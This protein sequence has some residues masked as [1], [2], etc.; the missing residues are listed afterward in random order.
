MSIMSYLFRQIAA[1]K[2]RE[3]EY[4]LSNAVEV[5][6]DK[7]LSLLQRHQDTVIGRRYGFDRITSPEKYSNSIPLS[8]YYSMEPLIKQVYEN[9]DGRILTVDPV[10][11][12]LRTSGSSGEPKKLPV[13]K[14]GLSEY[15]KGSTLLWMGYVNQH[16]DNAKVLDGTMLMFGAAAELERINGVPVGYASGV[17]PKMAN[18]LFKRL[19]KPGEDIFNI[20]DM[21]EKMK[22]Y[23]EY[24]VRHDITALIGIT[25]LCLAFVRRMQDEY[26]PWLL[27]RFRGT[28]HEQRVREAMVDG[29][30]LDLN[31]LWPNLRQLI[32][33]GIDT[34][35]YRDWMRKTL[36]NMQ[37]CEVYSSS[38]G[39]YASQLFEEP[40]VQIIPD[41]N[42]LEFIPEKEADKP[43]P[44]TIPLSDVRK[45]FRYE[46]V[47]TNVGGYYRYR[48]G[49][50]MTFTST[51]PY[52]VREIGRKGKLCNLAGEKISDS[53]VT[54][55]IAAAC[56]R[57]GAE[58]VDYSVVGQVQQKIG[59]PYYTIAAL[60]RGNDVNEE[61]FVSAY[62]EHMFSINE[63]YRVVREMGG[64]GPTILRRLKHSVFEERV[65]STG[66]IQA[67]PI[68]LTMDSTVLEMCEAIS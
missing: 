30:K 40:G 24:A 56:R 65:R 32:A 26:G 21:D 15:G 31:I 5:M 9:P 50:M 11:W 33:G 59:V 46:M 47:L 41:I 23:A 29:G 19:L 49:D 48:I 63:E 60:F 67:K 36:P 52:T 42:Y 66:S 34:D 35:P 39:W 27:E 17:S 20:M 68:P 7:L 28:K 22:V 13:T 16:P 57:T 10:F 62:E 1:R 3:I 54:K 58:L 51:D 12:Y 45:G 37:F 43:E 64:V 6:D 18:P 8:D 2:A 61:E 14:R 4:I 25:T 38:E 44:H 53:H 55:C